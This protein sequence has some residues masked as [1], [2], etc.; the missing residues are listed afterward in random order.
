M[1]I[2]CLPGE[3]FSSK[4]LQCWTQLLS[5]LNKNGIDYRVSFATATNI[6][7]VRNTCLKGLTDYDYVMWIDSDMVFTP[8]D[9]QELLNY[10]LP[11]VSG[12]AKMATGEWNCGKL[13]LI[14]FSVEPLKELNGLMEVDTCGMA[15]MLIKREVFEALGPDPFS[16][17]YVGSQFLGEDAGFCIKSRSHGYKIMVDTD[18][19]IGH[20]KSIVL[21]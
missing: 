18:V 2:F 17:L 20:E 19:R 8:D 10:D 5:Y 9:F 15:F 11:I 3:P 1:I 6:Y 4:F 21:K 7:N 13:D 14:N 16:P 12:I